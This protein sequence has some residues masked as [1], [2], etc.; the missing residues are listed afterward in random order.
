MKEQEPILNRMMTLP[1]SIGYIVHN[2]ALMDLPTPIFKIMWEI[3]PEHIK[4]SDIINITIDVESES[5]HIVSGSV[6]ATINNIHGQPFTNKL[7]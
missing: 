7:V 6:I 5:W 1:T 3:A 2:K 4:D